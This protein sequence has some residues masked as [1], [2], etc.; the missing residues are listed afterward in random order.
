MRVQDA[1]Q[2]GTTDIGTPA[3][4][5]M[6]DPDNQCDL[7]VWPEDGRDGMLYMLNGQ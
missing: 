7:R 2:E 4:L 1:S 3:Y 5:E 6:R